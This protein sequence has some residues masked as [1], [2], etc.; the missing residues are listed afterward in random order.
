MTAY[1][2]PNMRFSLETATAIARRRFVTVNGDGKAVL[3]A[4]G[5]KALG[6]SMNDPGENEVLEVAN[7]IVIVEAGGA[8]VA[9]ALVEAAA[10][11][12]A[13]T[14]AA[15]VLAGVA[16]TAA[17]ASGELISIML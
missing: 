5:E 6:A 1:E 9:G 12:K 13:V 8:I 11:G 16:M 14:Q 4:A 10:D 7:G 17:S 2:I 15:G 3:V